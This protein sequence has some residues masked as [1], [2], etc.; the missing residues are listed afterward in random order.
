MVVLQV[1][2]VTSLFAKLR[3]SRHAQADKE[4][5]DV[6]NP[7]TTTHNIRRSRVLNPRSLQRME[8]LTKFLVLI[9]STIWTY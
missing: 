2:F 3:F 5:E 8:K 9:E 6:E 4:F 7:Q 1:G